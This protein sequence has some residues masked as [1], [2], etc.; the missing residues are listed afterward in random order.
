MGH[1]FAGVVDEIGEGISKFKVGENVC[2]NPLLFDGECYPCRHGKPNACDKLGFRGLMGGGGAFSK[3][4]VLPEDSVYP[5]KH[6][7]T[8]IGALVEP[9]SVAWH[10]VVG[11][12]FQAG[13][14]AIIC[15]AGPI[16]CATVLALKA[17]GAR[18]VIMV[19]VAAA[20]KAQAKEFGADFVLDPKTDDVIAKAREICDG[21][22][23]HMSYDAAGIQATIDV[24]IK[25]VRAG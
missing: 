8:D 21:L 17:N 6:I 2:G 12:G 25:S 4:I 11:S 1:E 13:Q 16:G 23:P 9:L 10:A 18:R 20:R 24:C 19:E 3:Y 7:P 22:G 15:G 14:D 5:L